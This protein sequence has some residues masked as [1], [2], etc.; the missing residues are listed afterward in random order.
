MTRSVELRAGKSDFE[1]VS[2]GIH[3]FGKMDAASIRRSG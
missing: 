2:F 3:S 1:T